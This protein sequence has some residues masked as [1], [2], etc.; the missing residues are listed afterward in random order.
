MNYILFDEPYLREK[1]KPLTF[2]RPIADLRIGILT[3]KE[4]WEKYLNKQC[5]YS[6]APYLERYF[7]HRIEK[8]NLLINASICPNKEVVEAI[9]RLAPNEALI[10]ENLILALHVQVKHPG[11][12]SHLEI[13][14][15][16]FSL[17]YYNEPLVII[18]QLTDIF[19]YNGAE[20][21]ADFELITRNRTSQPI[22]DNHVITYKPENIFVEE[23][24][25]IKACILNA[26]RG[27][28]Y[29]GKNADIQEGSIIQG[30]FALCEGATINIGAKIR[31][32]TTIGPYCKVGGEVSN[33]VFLGYSNKAHDGF[34]GNSVIGEWCNLGADT[35]SSNLKNNYASVRLWSYPD[36]EFVDTGKQFCGL[37]MG[38]HSKCGINTMFNTGTVVGIACNIFGSGFPSKFI[39]SFSWGGAEGFTLHQIDKVLETAQ[40]VVERRGKTLSEKDKNLLTYLF[41]ERTRRY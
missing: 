29:I 32:D 19:S 24:A 34:L 18:K 36:N 38:D 28:I 1:L 31:P 26:E 25:K 23:G 35:N 22:L 27:K 40:R 8:D 5:S 12:V 17:V 11:E 6:T 16:N 41:E 10:Q 37:I 2:L 21:E 4:K 39:P 30:S 3:L 9:N 14:T 33:S 13:S 20:I 7:T 15:Q